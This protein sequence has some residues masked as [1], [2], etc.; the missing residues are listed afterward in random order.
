MTLDLPWW[1]WMACAICFFVSWLFAYGCGEANGYSA[2]VDWMKRQ[3]IRAG[4]AK[5]CDFDGGWRFWTQE[6]IASRLRP[7]QTEKP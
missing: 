7:T 2:G 3:A 5:A 1:G 4:V 6:E